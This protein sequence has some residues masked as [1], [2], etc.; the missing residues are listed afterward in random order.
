MNIE[1]TYCIIAGF[2]QP[3]ELIKSARLSKLH[4]LWFKK[5]AIKK[6]KNSIQYFVCPICASWLDMD[7]EIFYT[8]FK[9][10]YMNVYQEERKRYSAVRNILGYKPYSRRK[11]LCEEC[12]CNE[13]E[14]SIVKYSKNFMPINSSP[15]LRKIFYYRGDREYTIFIKNSPIM[16]W[17]FLFVE[18]DNEYYW[19]EI[20]V[21]IPCIETN[22][23]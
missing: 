16:S 13:L 3:L 4:A 8:D 19:N 7:D 10:V 2:L 20:D 12:E 11:L 18:K 14:I 6:Y 21:I 1:D 22:Y 23:Y 9:N 5:Y 17:A 15:Q